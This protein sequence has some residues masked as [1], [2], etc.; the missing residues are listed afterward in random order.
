MVTSLSKPLKGRKRRHCDTCHH[1]LEIGQVYWRHALPP[2][3]ELGN[4]GW[5]V[6]NTCGKTTD[7]CWAYWTIDGRMADK[8]DELIL[9]D[10]L[11]PTTYASRY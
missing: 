1:P 8:N 6:M 4:T 10:Q 9:I 3:S 11:G 2:N 7:K 5:W